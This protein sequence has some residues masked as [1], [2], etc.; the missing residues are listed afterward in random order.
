MQAIILQCHDRAPQASAGGDFVAGLELIQHRLPFFLTALLGQ[1]QE[2]IE[3]SKDEDEG[4]NTQPPHTA[5]PTEL[6]RQQRL[7]I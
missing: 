3:N 4:S 5:A 1:N 7:H 6:Y 2:K